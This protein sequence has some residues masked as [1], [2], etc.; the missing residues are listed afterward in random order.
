[1][2]N[3]V[4]FTMLGESELSREEG[5]IIFK[6]DIDG[7]KHGELKISKGGVRWK[8]FNGRD[9]R[10]ATWQQIDAFMSEKPLK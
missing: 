3:E 4:K 7:G 6:V 10:F 2:S 5:G 8:P 1:M 9:F